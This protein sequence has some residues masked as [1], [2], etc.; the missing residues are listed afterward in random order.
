M[1]SHILSVKRAYGSP[2]GTEV[3]LRGWVRSRRDSKGVT[4]IELNDGSRFKGMQLVVD[5]GV[6]RDEILKQIT[7]GSSLAAS[8]TLVE[9]PGKGQAV[10]LKVQEIKLYGSADPASYPLQKKG[11]SLE[12]L[13]EIS[14]LRVRSNTFGAA[15]RVRNALTHA[16]HTFFQERDFIYVQTPIITTSDCEGAG[17]MFA[18]T[19]LDLP[20]PPR[21]PEG[22]IDWTQDFFARPAYLTVSGQLEAEIFALGFSKVYTFGPTFRAENSN[23]PRHLAEFWM[24]EPEMAFYDL[25][26]NMQLAEEFLKYTIRYVLDHC[27]EDLEFFNQFIEKSVLATLEQVAEADFAHMAYTDAIKAVQ[28]AKRAWEFPVRWGSDLQTEHERFLSEEVFKK[29]VIVTDYPKNIKAFYMRLNDD[30][31][32]VRA[33][34]VLVPRVGEIIGGS[35]REERYDVLVERLRETGL[36]ERSYWWYLDLR[37]YGSV[38]H[39]G[40]GLGLERIMMYLTGLKNIRDVIPFPRTPGNADF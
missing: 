32:T 7:T 36:D 34:D 17:Q 20:N 28:D 21:T 10:E 39:S 8:G 27:R 38:P 16:I 23:T 6:V 24:I 14:H 18:V 25:E 11:H 33:M 15:F 29:P 26:D 12:F 30:N 13:R 5:A 35:Q 1:N 2:I 31:K 4:F 19:T 37:R 9:S 40:F 22:K 3:T